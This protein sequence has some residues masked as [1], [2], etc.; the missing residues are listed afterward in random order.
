MKQQGERE[1]SYKKASIQ[2]PLRNLVQKQVPLK[3]Q[4]SSISIR[5]VTAKH[6][7]VQYS[8]SD[9]Y[10]T[11]ISRLIRPSQLDAPIHNL[12][13]AKS[14]HL[15]FWFISQTRRTSGMSS[16]APQQV[17]ASDASFPI[18]LASLHM[19]KPECRMP[20]KKQRN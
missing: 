18:Q 10:L 17:P 2:A 19:S 1:L 9:P 11:F 7:I 15:I 14:F 20:H 8:L 3:H 6:L 16:L 5:Q 12:T 4:I 13:S